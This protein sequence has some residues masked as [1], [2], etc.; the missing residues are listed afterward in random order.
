MISKVQL[1]VKRMDPICQIINDCQQSKFSIA[2]SAELWLKFCNDVV[3]SDLYT[4]NMKINIKARSAMATNV[5][6]LA[7]NMMHPLYRG[8]RL[9][10][11]QKNLI[12]DFLIE[13]LDERGL[14]SL[15]EFKK[16]ESI[17]GTLAEK[18]I[19][20]PETFWGLVEERHPD[21]SKVASRLLKIP[22]SSAQLER[23]FS[24]WSWIHSPKR[25]KLT[26]ERSRKLIETY[27]SLKIRDQYTNEY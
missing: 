22:A 10:S 9:S 13:I 15:N 16:N 18:N 14:T 4:D 6:G 2:D 17:F 25:N 3:S 7:S 26:T 27:Y 5:Y 19:V 12:N 24:N 20:T 11:G 1:N 23:I 8:K 21:L